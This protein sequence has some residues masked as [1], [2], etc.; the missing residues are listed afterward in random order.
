MF[1]DFSSKIK[2]TIIQTIPYNYAK[3]SILSN[4]LLLGKP[5]LQTMIPMK[6]TMANLM[7]G[8]DIFTHLFFPK[9][10][11]YKSK[12]AKLYCFHS[13]LKLPSHYKKDSTKV[14]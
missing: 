7:K 2:E 8:S 10:R 9:I 11:T 3:L 13:P 5:E 12:Q 4:G 14:N 6:T 1:K